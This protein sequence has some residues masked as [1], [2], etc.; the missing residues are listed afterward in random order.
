VRILEALPVFL[1]AAD[2]QIAKEA[3]K[4]FTKQGLK[5]ELGVKITG[6]KARK[7]VTVEYA[8]AKANAERDFRSAHRLDRP[9]R[10]HRGLERR[11]SR[12][13]S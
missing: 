4:I 5:I 11:S 9:H 6:V 1:G 2:E 7:D 10:Q 3:W 13:Q 8:D 12:P